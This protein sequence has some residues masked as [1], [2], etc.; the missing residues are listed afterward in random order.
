MHPELAVV[1]F[2]GTVVLR[3]CII[4]DFAREFNHHLASE[5]IINGALWRIASWAKVIKLTNSNQIN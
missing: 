5:R 2:H 1:T 4:A 3:N